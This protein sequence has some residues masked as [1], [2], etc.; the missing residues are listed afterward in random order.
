MGAFL[1]VLLGGG[2]SDFISKDVTDTV[3]VVNSP[4]D[5]L[6]SAGTTVSFW[7][8]GNADVERYQLRVTQGGNGNTTL[9]MDTMLVVNDLL[10]EFS[11]NHAYQW[12]LRGVNEG[13]NTEWVGGWFL[14]DQ[15][16]PEK[17]T[18]TGLNGD[19][20]LV[21]GSGIL[22]WESA[23]L[24]IEGVRHGVA[25]SLLL[26]RRNDSTLVGAR[27]YYPIGAARSLVVNTAGPAPI[28]G[29]GTYSWRVVTF[30]AAGNR[31]VS[32]RFQFILQ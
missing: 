8:E 7:W 29:A 28:N 11:P 32:D 1:L 12:Q 25:D 22:R 13:S 18:A 4:A 24:A 21:G 16:A 15:T 19:T 31:K 27:F 17:A 6:Y 30:D 9:V 3:V 23:D 14:I 26:Y 5:S 10:V 20:V 2:C